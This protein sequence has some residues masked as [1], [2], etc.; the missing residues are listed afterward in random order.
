MPRSYF[1]GLLFE[2]TLVPSPMRKRH[3]KNFFG[4][5]AKSCWGSCMRKYGNGTKTFFIP[6]ED[7]LVNC[8]GVTGKSIV[9]SQPL[10]LHSACVEPEFKE[11][12]WWAQWCQGPRFSFVAFLLCHKR[13]NLQNLNGFVLVVMIHFTRQLLAFSQ[14]RVSVSD[15]RSMLEQTNLS[16]PEYLLT[17][18]APRKSSCW[19]QAT[20]YSARDQIK[21]LPYPAES[22][23]ADT[24]G[25]R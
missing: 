2:R 19:T 23:F 9:H 24:S 5:I 14:Q 10:M 21:R 22:F 16:S 11:H 15:A 6:D 8:R 7:E 12:D 4:D 1:G 13:T 18:S 20:V 25:R 17:A 3:K